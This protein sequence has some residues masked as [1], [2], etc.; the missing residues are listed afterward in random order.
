MWEVRVVVGG[1]F[2]EGWRGE[3]EGRVGDEVLRRGGL[4]ADS[5]SVV[6]ELTR[7]G[8]PW[9][10]ERGRWRWKVLHRV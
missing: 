3:A 4:S 8:Q 1:C 10:G 5:V 2:G 6:A 9:A 7:D